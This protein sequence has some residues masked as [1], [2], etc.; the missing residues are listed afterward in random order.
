MKRILPLLILLCIVISCKKSDPIPDQLLINSDLESALTSVW[1]NYGSGS[2][3]AYRTTEDSFSPSHS[4]KLAKT[5]IDTINFW[6]WSQKYIEKMPIGQKLT[7]AAKIKGVNLTGDGIAL[8]IRC[9]GKISGQQFATTQGTTKISGS[10]DWTDFS[11]D[12]PDLQDGVTG[13]FI[14]LIYMNK[15][16]GTV[17]FDDITL[18]YK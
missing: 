12:L 1:T 17:F 8:A 7:L 10:F 11:V 3:T 15:T 18:T 2:I 5:A 14:Y 6:Y 9:D 4:L 16:N 13:I